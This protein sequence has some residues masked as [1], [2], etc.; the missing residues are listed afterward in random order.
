MAAQ[1]NH[2]KSWNVFVFAAGDT[3]VFEFSIGRLWCY[4]GRT[5]GLV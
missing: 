4:N 5:L 3:L 1:A 2:L